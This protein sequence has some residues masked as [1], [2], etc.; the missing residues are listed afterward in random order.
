MPKLSESN[1]M[2]EQEASTVP[3]PSDFEEIV[4]KLY[5]R[6]IVLCVDNWYE[7][8]PYKR[9]STQELK[10]L[11]RAVNDLVRTRHTFRTLSGRPDWP[12][13]VTV[14]RFPPLKDRMLSVPTNYVVY[15]A[16]KLLD[17]GYSSGLTSSS[18][19][20]W[21]PP[22]YRDVDPDHPLPPT[23]TAEMERARSN[24]PEYADW[25]DIKIIGR[26]CWEMLSWHDDTQPPF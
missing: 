16:A 11:R 9:M 14:P 6:V 20:M 19:F 3:P 2:H 26:W 5:E 24:T 23:P 15:M 12:E 13:F 10:S 7:I 8:A 4:K 25:S 1:K 18:S 17:E 21:F 22:I